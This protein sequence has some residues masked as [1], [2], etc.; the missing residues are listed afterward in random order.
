MNSEADKQRSA[1]AGSRSGMNLAPT[2]FFKI[3]EPD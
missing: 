3:Y 1:N 2:Q